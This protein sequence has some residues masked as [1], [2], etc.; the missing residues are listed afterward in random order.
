MSGQ[1]HGGDRYR[2]TVRY[3]FSVNTN[4]LGMPDYVKRA[5][6]EK[7]QAGA[8]LWEWYPDP[9]CDSLRG[10]LASCH[11]VSREQIVC[12]NGASELICAIARMLS[13]EK[14]ARR[15]TCLLPVPSF[16]EYERALLAVGA[17][18]RYETGKAETGFALTEGILEAL[19]ADVDA[20]FL[21]SP[22]NP[23]GNRIPERLL[24][25]ILERCRQH[26]I[27]VV[28]AACFGELTVT[29]E[30]ADCGLPDAG[31]GLIVLKAFTKLYAIPG[32][33]LGYCIADSGAAERLQAQLPCWNVSGIAQLAGLT[34]LDGGRNIDYI[35]QT[36]KYITD[37]RNFLLTGLEKLGLRVLPGAANFLCFY[38]EAPLYETLLER[39]ILIRD[40]SDYR[41]MGRGWYRIAVRTHRENE[42]LLEEIKGEI[43]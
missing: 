20:V 25:R 37:E 10:A 38:S 27:T 17:E 19:T 15:I 6:R 36:R 42:I 18:I 8:E 21:C 35:S 14:A 34:I 3:D 33:R 1:R 39:G 12:G 29:G 43:G 24:G 31:P 9:S 22:N 5:L 40:C 4:P 28:F 23:V 7:I 16:S 26:G 13:Q 41:G 2:H 30:P 11:G 32:L